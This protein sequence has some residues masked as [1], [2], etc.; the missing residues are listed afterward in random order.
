MEYFVEGIYRDQ[1]FYSFANSLT[2]SK[3]RVARALPECARVQVPIH[4]YHVCPDYV[5]FGYL[6]LRGRA[7]QRMYSVVIGFERVNE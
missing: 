6:D 4:H 3:T 2:T 1:I 7:R 5:L